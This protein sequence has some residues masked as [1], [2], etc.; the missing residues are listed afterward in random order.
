MK[1]YESPKAAVVAFEVV[2]IITTSI[3]T[4]EDTPEMLTTWGNRIAD[5]GSNSI[6]D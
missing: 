1:I 6:F 3:P 4:P 2:D 5:V